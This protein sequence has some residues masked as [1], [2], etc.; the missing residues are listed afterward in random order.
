MSKLPKEI[1]ENIMEEMEEN[2]IYSQAHELR[3]V[4]L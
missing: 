4:P 1:I 2:T 3:A